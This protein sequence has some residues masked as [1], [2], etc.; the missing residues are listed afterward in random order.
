MSEDC[1]VQE[2]VVGK[3]LLIYGHMCLDCR[4]LPQLAMFQ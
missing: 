3:T 4:S 1:V 2:Y